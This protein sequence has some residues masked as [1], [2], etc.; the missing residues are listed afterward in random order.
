VHSEGAI[1]TYQTVG[2]A[3]LLD[4][5][6]IAGPFNAVLTYLGTLP[7]GQLIFAQENVLGLTTCLDDGRTSRAVRNGTVYHRGALSCGARADSR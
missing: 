7:N 5:D 3:I 1:G 2:N 4:I 6:N